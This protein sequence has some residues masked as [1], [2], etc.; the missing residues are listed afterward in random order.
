LLAFPDVSCV[1]AAVGI[2]DVAW[3]RDA[4][5][6]S[7][8]VGA[9]AVVGFFSGVSADVVVSTGTVAGAP[10]FRFV[11]TFAEHNALVCFPAVYGVPAADGCPAVVASAHGAAGVFGDVGAG[12]GICYL[13]ITAPIHG[14][15]YLHD[16]YVSP[17]S[18]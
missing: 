12:T 17:V 10:A 5:D 15:G 4:A 6:V 7:A 2:L 18:R 16:N 14:A 11:P 8:V 13:F 3:A 9:P 1:P